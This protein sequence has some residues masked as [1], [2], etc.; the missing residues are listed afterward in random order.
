MQVFAVGKWLV[1]LSL[2]IQNLGFMAENPR[3]GGLEQEVT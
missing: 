2:P 3:V 1:L